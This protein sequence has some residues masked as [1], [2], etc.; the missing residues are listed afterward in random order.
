MATPLPVR[1]PQPGVAIRLLKA[2]PLDGLPTKEKILLYVQQAE[3][4]A[5]PHLHTLCFS[6]YANE[7]SRKANASAMLKELIE[8][9]QL[10]MQPFGRGNIYFTG[11]TPNPTAHNV[12]VRELFVKLV[13]TGFAIAELNFSY[14]HI[15]GLVPDLYVGFSAEGGGVVST[16]W[17]YDTGT[18]GMSVIEQKLKRYRAAAFD[19]LVFVVAG[20]GR[21]QQLL[22]AMSEPG[23]YVV[24]LDELTGLTES[25]FWTPGQSEPQALFEPQ[26]E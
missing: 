23:V 6:H 26:G 9:R 19:R 3:Y 12:A 14:E 4:L 11:R 7:N 13:S 10:K 5:T 18:E 17:E 1:T 8:A 20:Q 16:F 25:V 15:P 22:R 24:Q 2:E 21:Q